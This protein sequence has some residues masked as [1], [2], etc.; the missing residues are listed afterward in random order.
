MITSSAWGP[1]PR[2][3][4]RFLDAVETE[5]GPAP[6]LVV[7]GSAD[8]KFVL[9]ASGQPNRRAEVFA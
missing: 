8:G 6:S 5:V 9:S 7:V 2:R 4:L 1:V 3:F